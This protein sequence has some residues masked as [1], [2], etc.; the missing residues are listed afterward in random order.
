MNLPANLFEDPKFL[1]L[2]CR[3][4]DV[5][6]P[7]F[8]KH[9]FGKKPTKPGHLPRPFDQG[10]GRFF[11]AGVK[12]LSERFTLG[13]SDLAARSPKQAYFN[14]PKFRS[15]YFLYFFPL[16]CA[17]ILQLISRHF[18]Q[19]TLPTKKLTVLDVGAGPGTASLAFLLWLT[20]R[21]NKTPIEEVE[22]IWTDLSQSIMDD[23]KKLIL[24]LSQKGYFGDLKFN[25][26][27]YVNSLDRIPLAHAP[28]FVLAAN[29]LNECMPKEFEYFT[30]LARSA[31]LGGLAVEPAIKNASQRISRLRETLARAEG[32][33]PSTILGP[34]LHAG[35]CPLLEGR[36]WCHFSDPLKVPGNWFQYFSTHIGSER[37]W[38]K[39][40]YFCFKSAKQPHTPPN[41]V[42]QR[43][44]I[45]DPIRMAN[46]FKVLLCEPNRPRE[47]WITGKNVDLK[48]GYWITPDL[49]RRSE[50]EGQAPRK[51][52]R[53]HRTRR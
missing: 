51:G 8:V 14:Q 53:T 10:D 52:S 18:D 3:L 23:G 38:M 13:R 12:E 22:F 25:I 5:E 20:N 27:Y 19:F 9:Q 45:S 21:K 37:H 36:D 11:S 6:V 39:Y 26:R 40:S 43:L 15:S 32:I 2:W 4:F 47:Y 1:D 50:P 29:I 35:A 41:N 48:R 34:C 44:V 31:S 46:R 49:G 42:K 24:L 7:N 17:K 16:N 28:D 30:A 33:P